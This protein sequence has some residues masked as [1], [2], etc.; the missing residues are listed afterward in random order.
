MNAVTGAPVA[1]G[2]ARAASSDCRLVLPVPVNAAS[3][4]GV[5]LCLARGERARILLKSF[6]TF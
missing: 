4:L 1:V 5:N 6:C 3:R 2:V